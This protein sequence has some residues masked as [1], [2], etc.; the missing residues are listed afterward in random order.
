MRNRGKFDLFVTLVWLIILGVIGGVVLLVYGNISAAN[1]PANRANYWK[2]NMY[3]YR[4]ALERGDRQLDDKKYDAARQTYQNALEANS[5]NRTSVVLRDRI[6]RAYYREGLDLHAAGNDA[7]AIRAFRSGMDAVD[8]VQSAAGAARDYEPRYQNDITTAD[9]MV[10]KLAESLVAE[11]T[12]LRDEDQ[13]YDAAENLLKEA[14]ERRPANLGA[15]EQLIT[16]YRETRRVSP[17]L[18]SLRHALEHFPGPG[19]PQFDQA[20]DHY[21]QLLTDWSR[22]HADTQAYVLNTF[23]ATDWVPMADGMVLQYHMVYASFDGTEMRGED[24]TRTMQMTGPG[25]AQLSRRPGQPDILLSWS[26][27]P[28]IGECLVEQWTPNI[29]G[30]P[31]PTTFF[32]LPKDNLRIGLQWRNA[33][34]QVFTLQD[35]KSDGGNGFKLIITGWGQNPNPIEI[36]YG[37][38]R[39]SVIPHESGEGEYLDAVA[40]QGGA[41]STGG[42]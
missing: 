19:T 34:G 39:T 15:S 41:A 6:A 16:L 25:A 21:K 13:N 20:D 12:R 38:G 42:G 14:R 22:R 40:S 10:D 8:R 1:D 36:T 18:F 24:F 29:T 28:G 5:Q 32:L 7:E 35:L 17:L 26:Q 31:Q 9:M 33:D 4:S 3:G 37:L 30:V 27:V 23:P 11:G 2:E